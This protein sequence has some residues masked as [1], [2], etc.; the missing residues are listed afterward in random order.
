MYI[1]IPFLR[2]LLNSF[3]PVDIFPSFLYNINRI[4]FNRENLMDIQRLITLLNREEGPK[5]DFKLKLNIDMESGK[6]ELAK[7][8][9]AIA[10]SRGGRGHILF[11]IEDK[12]K[13]IVGINPKEFPEEQLQ[14]IVS[15]RLDPPVPISVDII[16]INNVYVGSIT[17]FNTDQRPHQ[18]RDTGAF[19]TRRGSTT[20]IMR[21]EEIASMLQEGGL[22]NYELTPVIRASEDDLDFEKLKDFFHKSGLAST[23]DKN[24][25]I[26]SGI[27]HRERDYNEFHPTCGGMLL[28][29]F[30]PQEFLP[31]AL[32][33]IYNNLNPA[34]P[35][36]HVSTGDI[37]DMLEDS[38]DFIGKCLSGKLNVPMEIMADLIGK[39]VLHRD[40]FDVN[41]SIEV[42]LSPRKIEISN[43]GAAKREQNGFNTR[44]I[45]RNSW[46]YLKLL[47]LDNNNRFFHKNINPELLIQDVGV[48]KYYSIPSKNTFKATINLLK[49][50]K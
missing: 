2:I 50:K 34:L 30:R 36:H 12:T 6:K 17:I 1:Y 47:T 33:K 10:N 41:R 9:C 49:N 13:S 24:L 11:G 40:Y 37:I 5:L 48:I 4:L 27:I 43:P 7:D 8:V 38:I 3:I 23:L 45:R 20:D 44:Y 28:F 35:Y 31:H 21:K 39:A 19:Y 25:L 26:S 16:K 15:T 29:G 18:M 42:Y 46:L 22:L 14:Q 32:I